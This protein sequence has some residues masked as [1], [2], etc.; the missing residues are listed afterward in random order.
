MLALDLHVVIADLHTEVFGWEVLDVQV[1]CEL[2]P[3]RPHL[4]DTY[5]HRKD[6]L[7]V[8]F[9]FLNFWN[10]KLNFVKLCWAESQL[11]LDVEQLQDAESNQTNPDN[12]YKQI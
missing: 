6:P 5:K 2:V 10:C 4:F 11:C 9:F 3:V 7:H 12:K 8:F 1:D